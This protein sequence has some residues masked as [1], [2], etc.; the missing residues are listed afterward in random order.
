MAENI[1]SYTN[2]TF[3]DYRTALRNYTKSYY[4]D[5]AASYDDAE[6]GSWWLDITAG[7]ADELSY[8]IDRALQETNIESA[9]KRSSVLAIAR[10]NGLKIP[11]P[12]GSL[13][14]EQI[15]VVLPPSGDNSSSSLPYP[16]W[17]YAPVIK[18]GTIFTSGSL[19]FEL[20]HNVDFAEEFDEN[21]YANRTV[22][23]RRDSNGIIT[24]YTVSKLAVIVAGQS[25]IYK[26]ELKSSDITPFMEITLP[27]ANVMNVESVIIKDGTDWQQNP[28][29]S[30]FMTEDEYTSS[31]NTVSQT[32]TYRYFEVNS[33]A[34]QYR[35]GDVLNS[36]G[37]PAIYKYAVPEMCGHRTF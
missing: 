15:S 10:T 19:A 8:H 37:S 5:I 28:D 25:I 21:G 11:G 14:E 13:A 26:K 18:K 29:L 24:A 3:D 6:I 22:L 4:P 33:L 17:N 32:E 35:F 16:N 7:I 31:A 12:K 2:R 20:M 34:D 23:P 36:D 9:Q 1:I 27:G 30:E